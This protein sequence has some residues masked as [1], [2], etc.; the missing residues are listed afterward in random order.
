M[1]DQTLEERLFT[2]VFFRSGRSQCV[3]VSYKRIS[4]SLLKFLRKRFVRTT[5][6]PERRLI[7]VYRFIFGRVVN[8]LLVVSGYCALPS[9]SRA[10]PIEVVF[11]GYILYNVFIVN[12]HG[13]VSTLWEYPAAFLQCCTR[14][15]SHFRDLHPSRYL[16]HEGVPRNLS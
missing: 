15:M 7:A 6:S 12:R 9:F 13:V 4:V 5:C 8:S 14:W 1:H 11:A 2:V 10:L 3:P 16:Q